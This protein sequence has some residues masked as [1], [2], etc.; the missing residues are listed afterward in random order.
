MVAVGRITTAATPTADIET[1]VSTPSNIPSAHI[2]DAGEDNYFAK[3][4]LGHDNIQNHHLLQVQ[5]VTFRLPSS[6]PPPEQPV[7]L[8]I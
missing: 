2:L 8:Q 7:L 3:D 1:T 4:L 5:V 6:V